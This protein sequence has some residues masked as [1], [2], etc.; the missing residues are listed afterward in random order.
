[1]KINAKLLLIKIYAI[2][3]NIMSALIL[4][5]WK[6]S[7]DICIYLEDKL[8]CI[9]KLKINRVDVEL[10]NVVTQVSVMYVFIFTLLNR[11]YGGFLLM[12]ACTAVYEDHRK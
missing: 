11:L 2:E 5:F 3:S 8:C 6:Y 1:M 10:H 9:S 12:N 4:F 7:Y